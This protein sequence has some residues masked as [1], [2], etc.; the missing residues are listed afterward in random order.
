MISR[1]IITTHKISSLKKTHFQE[2]RKS[3]IETAIRRNVR[4]PSG[5]Y[6]AVRAYKLG[7]KLASTL[8]INIHF[9]PHRERLFL[10]LKKFVGECYIEKHGC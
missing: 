9:V 2:N 4:T 1:K 5:F 6:A 7:N 3:L 10:S 8:Y